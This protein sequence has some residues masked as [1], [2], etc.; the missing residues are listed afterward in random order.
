[1]HFATSQ[2]RLLLMM[3][4]LILY[5]AMLIVPVSCQY[6]HLAASMIESNVQRGQGLTLGG[7]STGLIELVRRMV[8]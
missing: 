6:F 7:Q 3:I 4:P 2:V 8:E 1:M 5:G